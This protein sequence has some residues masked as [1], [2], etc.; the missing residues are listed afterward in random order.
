MSV[1][2]GGA[3][4]V[5]DLAP[6]PPI[7][8]SSPDT[9]STAYLNTQHP[10]PHPPPSTTRH[11]Q[12]G[13]DG[14]LRWV[15]YQVGF[16]LLGLLG[17]VGLAVSALWVVHIV[18]YMLPPV[19]IHPMLNEVFAKLD[20]VFPLFGVAAFAAFCLYLM[21]VAVKGNF[22]L[23]LNFLVVKLYPVRPGATLT[24]SLLVNVA[25]VL[26]MSG[27]VTQFCASAFASYAANTAVFEIF[28]NDV[29]RFGC[30]VAVVVV[31]LWCWVS[32]VC[33][34]LRV[35]CVLRTAAGLRPT[36]HPNTPP[37]TFPNLH[38]N[39]HPQSR[40]PGPLPARPALRLPVQ[41][42][43]LHAA[44]D[45]GRVAAVGGRARRGRAVEAAQAGLGW[46]DRGGGGV[47]RAAQNGRRGTAAR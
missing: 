13:Q 23:G 28:G 9:H 2:A 36:Q 11:R 18:I 15:L 8:I 42:V 1:G 40:P 44:V 46:M 33:C 30:L 41:R 22:L 14:E 3:W 10:T 20:G 29:R 16:L 21:A 17:V 37:P 34:V 5:L 19:P 38:T 25:L 27:A 6:L 35:R 45:R 47:L 26:A 4:F 7:T 12:Q 31:V 43:P 24:S 39:D 32:R